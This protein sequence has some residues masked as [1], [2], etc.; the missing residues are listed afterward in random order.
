MARRGGQLV[1][2]TGRTLALTFFEALIAAVP[3]KIHT[4]CSPTMGSRF[5]FPPRCADGQTAS[6][7]THK[8]DMRFQENAIE[9]RLT[10]VK[11]PWTNAQVERMNRTIKGRGRPTLPLR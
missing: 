8:F 5:A 9:D 6:Y 11:H 3:C 4:R 10:K 1:R 7:V 2:K